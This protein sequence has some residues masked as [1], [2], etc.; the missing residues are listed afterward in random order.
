M[1]SFHDE[2]R[3]TDC[4]VASRRTT[5]YSATLSHDGAHIILPQEAQSF[6][7]GLE[8]RQLFEDYAKEYGADWLERFR[9]QLGWPRSNSLYLLTGFYKTCSW[10]IASFS[11]RTAANTN[12]VH[13]HCTLK[14]VDDR[15]IRDDSVWQPAGRFKR[16]IGPA[17][18]RQGRNN[19]SVFIRGFTI[20]CKPPEMERSERQ[21]G[22][23]GVISTT[24]RFLSTLVGASAAPTAAE[25]P[26]SDVMVQHVP[27]ISQV[28]SV[29]DFH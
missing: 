2:T 14:E 10:S 19:Q 29:L 12:P 5:Q 13:V 25:T 21:A 22:L 16:K 11:M 23:L 9:R 27:Q 1:A 26:E 6:E 15:V 4:G 17:P 28:F 20:T 7:L 8:H 18:D 24:T 3:I